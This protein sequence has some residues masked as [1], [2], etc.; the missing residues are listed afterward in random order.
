MGRIPKYE[1]FL[2]KMIRRIFFG[3]DVQ[4]TDE[5]V[6][7]ISSL[8]KQASRTPQDEIAIRAYYGLDCDRATDR[9][10]A[11]KL[12]LS[13]TRIQQIRHRVEQSLKNLLV[14]QRRFII[15]SS[16]QKE[17]ME[18]LEEEIGV[19]K[20]KIM[21]LQ[22]HISSSRIEFND[23]ISLTELRNRNEISLKAGYVMKRHKMKTLGELAQLTKEEVMQ[24]RGIGKKTLGEIEDLLKKYGLSLAD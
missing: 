20:K 19:L 6:E 4:L 2:S 13:V 23:C 10:T 3:K 18:S 5:Q 14:S 8:I 11:K 24:G 16:A 22:N 15:Q 21:E 17:V 7:E 9:E 12:N 1:L